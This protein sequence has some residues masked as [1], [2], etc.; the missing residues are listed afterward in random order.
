MRFD[1][2]TLAEEILVARRDL[3][4]I[5]PFTT[6]WPD[7]SLADGYRVAAGLEQQRIAAGETPVG[8]KIGF[9]NRNIWREYGVYAPILGTV[10]DTTLRD[11]TTGEPIA[12]NALSQPRLE[13]EIIIGLDRGLGPGASLADAE[14]A[15]AWIAHG[16]EI[17]QTL[18]DD[19]K[20]AAP[21]CIAEGGLHGLLILGPTKVIAP[22][23]RRGLAAR[24]AALNIELRCNGETIDRG[25]GANV[26]DGPVQAL[27]F[28][29]NAIAAE[30][31]T[32][33]LTD[34]ELV[35]TG[36]MTRAFPISPGQTWSTA[37]SGFDLPGLNVKF[38]T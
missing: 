16:F 30:P 6:R 13:P 26:L 23:E 5:T 19:W 27:A 7:F 22:Q 31:F 9:T 21:D 17:V 37:I 12:I 35:S 32:R 3:R 25:A 38:A 33:P 4:R 15:V 34:G 36:T 11:A 1:A 18:F 29:A 10:Y 20:F 14:D 28:A 8:R 2:S 24:L